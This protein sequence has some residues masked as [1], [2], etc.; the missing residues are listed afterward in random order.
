[1]LD[2]WHLLWRRRRGRNWITCVFEE[3][4]RM[5]L[6]NMTIHIEV[7]G[8]LGDCDLDGETMWKTR[9][10]IPS[11]SS[12][13]F[14]WQLRRELSFILFNRFIRFCDARGIVKAIFLLFCC[15]WNDIVMFLV[16][17]YMARST[18]QATFAGTY[19]SVKWWNGNLLRGCRCA[20]QHEE[21]SHRVLPSPSSF[22][23]LECGSES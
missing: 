9:T 8:N 4:K 1:M 16:E 6:G 5:R 22:R 12:F 19:I 17:N 3:N 18:G 15:F 20:E 23:H 7:A 11:M 10:S 13:T 2:M 14:I 21:D